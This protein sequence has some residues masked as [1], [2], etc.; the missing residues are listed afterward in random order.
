MAGGSTRGFFLFRSDAGMIDAPTW[1][2]HAA[3]L[4]ALT[5]TLV[6]VW[7]LLSPYA[8]RDLKTSAFLAPMTILAYSYLIVFAFA[9]LLIAV[10]FTN[11]SAKRLRERGLPAGLAGL[12]PLLALCAGAAHWLQPQVPDVIAVWY[13]VGLDVLLAC[14]VAWTVAMLGMERR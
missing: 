14:T 4:A 1:R 13:V 6:G 2:F 11:L 10:S 3:W 7:L 8:H 12:V 9:V 5:A